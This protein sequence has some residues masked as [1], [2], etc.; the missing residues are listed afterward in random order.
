VAADAVVDDNATS[1]EDILKY[2]V[3]EREDKFPVYYPT[4]DTKE[5][6]YATR[7]EDVY[8]QPQY[9]VFI[10][11]KEVSK[12]PSLTQELDLSSVAY[13]TAHNVLDQQHDFTVSAS[14]GSSF[15]EINKA[16][17]KLPTTSTTFSLETPFV[18]LFSPPVETEG[19]H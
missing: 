13:P 8:P 14:V 16:V 6:P 3:L 5:V 2:P 18:N 12:Y 10:S 17:T 19:K 11:D 1:K 15:P 7:R 9:P 4:V